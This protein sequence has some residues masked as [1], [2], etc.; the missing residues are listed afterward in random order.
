MIYIYIYVICINIYIF[1]FLYVYIYIY[2]LFI[3][4][5]VYSIYMHIFYTCS[6]IVY[7]IVSI[8]SSESLNEQLIHHDVLPD[9]DPRSESRQSPDPLQDYAFFGIYI[10]ELVLRFCAFGPR[11]VKSN[12][13]KFD[14]FLVASATADIIL[15]AN[16]GST[17]SCQTDE[18]F[19][20]Q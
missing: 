6:I 2:I 20:T 19:Q 3:Y 9:P 18:Y 12:W 15:K 13:V 16:L 8:M 7:C 14:L 4:I 5:Y 11:V 10:L 17:D 1:I